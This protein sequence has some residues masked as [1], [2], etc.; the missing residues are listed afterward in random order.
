MTILVVDVTAASVDSFLKSQPRRGVAGLRRKSIKDRYIQ[1]DD[2]TGI[3]FPPRSR[4][5]SSMLC[6]EVTDGESDALPPQTL[7]YL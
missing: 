7:N 1:G 3:R 2:V 4:L 6:I 5:S